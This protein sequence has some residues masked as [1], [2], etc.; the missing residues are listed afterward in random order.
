MGVLV[1]WSFTT[2]ILV[3]MNGSLPC[4]IVIDQRPWITQLIGDSWR[5]LVNLYPMSKMTDVGSV[6]IPRALVSLRV[7]PAP[8]TFASSGTKA[9]I[10]SPPGS[11]WRRECVSIQASHRLGGVHTFWLWVYGLKILKYGAGSTPVLA[12]HCQPPLLDARSP[13]IRTSMKCYTSSVQLQHSFKQ[14]TYARLTF[15]PNRQSIIKSLVR[16]MAAIIRPR[17]C[18]QP[19]SFACRIAAS[20]MGTPVRP[21]FHA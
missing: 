5:R 6:G 14:N 11:V 13:S 16:Y 10:Y 15:S 4:L 17:L 19:I 8:L 3:A 7:S 1:H 20:T 12:L 18:I 9:R 2:D 21:S